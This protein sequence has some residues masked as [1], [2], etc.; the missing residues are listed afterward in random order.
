M[1]TIVLAHRRP[2]PMI[3]TTAETVRGLKGTILLIA[4]IPYIVRV[5]GKGRNGCILQPKPS[6]RTLSQLYEYQVGYSTS[7]KKIRLGRQYKDGNQGLSKPARQNARWQVLSFGRPLSDYSQSSVLSQ[8]TYERQQMVYFL[9]AA[10]TES[11]QVLTRR[12][13]ILCVH[14][15]SSSSA[16][17]G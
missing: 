16:R 8:R 6:N 13:S 1:P 2:I 4:Q 3:R 9:F 7:N 17:P 5:P 15:T 12:T 14:L 10:I 11:S